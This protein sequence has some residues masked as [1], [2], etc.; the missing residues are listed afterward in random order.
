MIFD[1]VRGIKDALKQDLALEFCRNQNRIIIIL[2][3]THINYDQIY[4][5]KNEMERDGHNKA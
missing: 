2:T 1:H 4:H 3:E 5:V